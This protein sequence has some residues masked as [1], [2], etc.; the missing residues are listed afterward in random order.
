VLADES[1]W[2]VTKVADRH[3]FQVGAQGG[4]GPEDYDRHGV[5]PD[6]D[7]P[8]AEWG[9]DPELLEDVHRVATATGHPV[10]VLR[11]PDPHALSGP[12]ADLQHAWLTGAGVTAD[13]LL[14]ESFLLIDPTRTREAGLVPLW[15]MFPVESA[16]HTTIDHLRARP[17]RYRSVHIGLFPHG[18]RSRGIAE[19]A[20]WRDTL[21]VTGTEVGFVGVD[22]R[23]YP[24][25][26]A[27]LVR[28]GAEL[29]G[30][31]RPARAAP[32]PGTL[33]IDLALEALTARHRGTH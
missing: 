10:H 19:P 22:P 15:T 29:R 27:A 24:A 12:V 26:F 17:N 20:L 5:V 3:V 23:R 28:Y 9:F 25:D 13:R 30:M 16:V 7:A 11:Y 21:T 6:S 31:P 1:T 32:M 33:P 4:I 2:P 14:V 8:E 18:V